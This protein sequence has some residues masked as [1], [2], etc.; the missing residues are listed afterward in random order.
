MLR[1]KLVRKVK[2]FALF[3][4]LH[5]NCYPFDLNLVCLFFLCNQPYL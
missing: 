3:L 5:M 2:N 1:S 4:N